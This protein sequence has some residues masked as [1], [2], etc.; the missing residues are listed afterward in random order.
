MNNVLV[1]TDNDILLKYFLEIINEQGLVKKHKFDFYYSHKNTNPNKL[2]N[3]F[4]DI[5]P[6]NLRQNEEYILCKYDILI[7]LHCKQIFPSS[8]VNQ[9][10]CINVHPG[11]NPYNRGYYSHIFSI[12]N[13]KPAGATIHFMDEKIDHGPIIDRKQ[14]IIE[15]FDDSESLYNKII[16][17]EVELLRKNLKNILN[18]NI[19]TIEPEEEGNFNSKEDFRK[20]CKIDLGEELSFKQAIDKLRALTHGDYN[21]AFFIDEEGNKIYIK[22]RFKK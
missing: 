12:I 5:K 17:A 7:S 22:I 1:I 11:Y 14:V 6:L 10:I 9:K 3:I 8:L 15:A 16:K 20:L 2:Y 4:K 13:K 19:K 18:N 21:N